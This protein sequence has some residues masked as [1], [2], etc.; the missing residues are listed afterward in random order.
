MSL[1]DKY[2]A[3]STLVGLYRRL[4]ELGLLGSALEAQS[5]RDAIAHWEREL[6]ALQVDSP[7]EWTGTTQ[8]A[9]EQ[10]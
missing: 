4:C 6:A 7:D 8:E 9:S 2:C 3:T 5:V 1:Q 10:V